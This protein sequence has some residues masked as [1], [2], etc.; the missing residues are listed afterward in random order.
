[1]PLQRRL[2]KRGFRNK[3]RQEYAIINIGEI[4]KRI[5]NT[6]LVDSDFLVKAGLLKSFSDPV[7]IL[8]VGGIEKPITVKAT[9]FS[10][11]AKEK[12]EKSG[13]KAERC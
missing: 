10:K 4:S 2:P 13:G 5:G 9:S 12:I 11:A 6:T 3:F 7:K 1:M 8:G